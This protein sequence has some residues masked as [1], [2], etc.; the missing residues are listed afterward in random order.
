MNSFTKLFICVS[1]CWM[2]F[3]SGCIKYDLIEGPVIEFRGMAI[4]DKTN[5]PITNKNISVI[6]V[7]CSGGV[8]FGYTEERTLGSAVIDSKGNFNLRFTKWNAA[9][10]FKF[11]ISDIPGYFR[12]NFSL[13]AIEINTTDTVLKFTKIA[14]MKIIFKNIN[15]VDSNDALV[16]GFLPTEGDNG[17]ITESC[18]QELFQGNLAIDPYII[19]GTAEG[20]KRCPVGADR[21]FLILWNVKKNGIS[22]SFR[23]SVYCR[24]N[25]TTNYHLNY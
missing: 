10:Y 13:D 15:P 22:G 9:K 3:A 18:H 8:W 11:Y 5:E 17:Y 6:G 14:Y 25:D 16:F 12:R 7:Y 20:F 24:R 19:K 4:D 1:L 21:K 23:D 2:L